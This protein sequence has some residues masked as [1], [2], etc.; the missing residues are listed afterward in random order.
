MTRLPLADDEPTVADPAQRT[1]GVEAVAPKQDPDRTEADERRL[2][3]NT[4]SPADAIIV[5]DSETRI[6]LMNAVAERLTG[7][8]SSAALG[9]AVHEVL[10]IVDASGQ[11]L[12]EA[13]RRA[14]RDGSGIRLPVGARVVDARGGTQEIDD[15]TASRLR[16]EGGVAG[17]L[18]IF[19]DVT[20]RH[21]LE[22]R[23]ALTERLASLSMMAAAMAHEINNPVAAAIGNVDFAARRLRDLQEHTEANELPLWAKTLLTDVD[24]ALTDAQ[25]AGTRVRRIVLDLRK[26]ARDD[27]VKL[28]VL[29]VSAAIKAALKITQTLVGDTAITLSLGSTPLVEA[30]EGR[31][32]QVF[33]NLIANGLQA[34]KTTHAAVRCL[35]ILTSTDR[36]GRAVVDISDNGIGMTED[37]RSHLFEPFFTTSSAQGLGLGLVMCQ[38]A[39]AA[40]GGQIA[41]ESATGKGATFR[42]TLPAASQQELGA[43]A[44]RE[45]PAAA[46]RRG[47]IIVIDDEPAVA[48]MI[49]RHLADEHDVQVITDPRVALAFI[50]TD[51]SWDIVLCDM[52]MPHVNGMMIHEAIRLNHPDRAQ[53]IVYLT[54]GVQPEATQQFLDTSSQAIIQK[55]L[56]VD[57][58]KAAVTNLLR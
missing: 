41:V 12:A 23:R 31:L 47:R 45:R 13:L 30:D 19:K 55:P 40:L 42:V 39:V 32:V 35:G 2:A 16:G 20:E 18:I 33:A 1:S 51:S 53:R 43:K 10:K 37:V 54:G 6:T 50:K 26:L 24:E 9:R 8:T 57:Q 49:A 4:A 58:L 7:C 3:G 28:E 22:Q 46:A 29:D 48:A 36:E 15:L 11:P 56:N 34:V 5:T 21:R 25:G 44:P 17:S 27:E 52:T 14:A 38:S